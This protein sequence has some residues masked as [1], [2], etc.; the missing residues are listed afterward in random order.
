MGV[1]HLNSLPKEKRIQMIGEFYDVVDSLKNRNEIRSFFKDLL[2][3]EEIAS[4]MRRIE[5]AV[6]LEAGFSYPKISKIIGAGNDKIARV[7]KCLQ[8]DNSG[9]KII[10]DRLMENRKKW[11]KKK[12]IK[13]DGKPVS[14]LR[15][16]H[17]LYFAPF[18]PSILDLAVD[19]PDNT[20]KL[21]EKK[22]LY[23]TPSAKIKK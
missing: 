5:I 13:V 9:Y 22:A 20:E 19:S 15:K 1:F 3:A 7:Q 8:Q 10:V 6:L 17:P 12:G 11:L 2:S 4:F 23:F 18:L 21:L 16:T 14:R